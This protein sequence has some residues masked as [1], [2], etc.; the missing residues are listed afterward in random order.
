MDEAKPFCISKEEVWM[1][2]KR[3][4]ANRGAAGIDGQSIAEFEEDMHST[5]LNRPQKITR[6]DDARLRTVGGFSMSSIFPVDIPFLAMV[7]SAE[8]YTHYAS[9]K[10]PRQYPLLPQQK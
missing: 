6:M 1:A 9:I 4:K 5:V 2:Y 7:I 8:G 3:V 10:V